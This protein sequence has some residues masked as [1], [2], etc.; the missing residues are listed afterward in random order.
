MKRLIY[1]IFILAILVPQAVSAVTLNLR[2]PIPPGAPNINSPDGQALDQVIAWFYYFIIWIAGFATFVMIIV[3]GVKWLTSAG[4]PSR[5][6][7]AKD[8][9]KNAIL[10]LLIILAAFIILQTI[11]PGLTTLVQP[12]F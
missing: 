3:G 2:Y 10:G 7:D 1:F 6:T 11:N 4:N 8:Q 5:I 9:I 12:M